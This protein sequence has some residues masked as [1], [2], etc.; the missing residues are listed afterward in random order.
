[1]IFYDDIIPYNEERRLSFDKKLENWAKNVEKNFEEKNSYTTKFNYNF[2]NVFGVI[3]VT[4]NY[5]SVTQK[6]KTSEGEK[7]Y[8]LKDISSITITSKN[9]KESLIE[10]N[11]QSRTE[12]LPVLLEPKKAEAILEIIKRNLNNASR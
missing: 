7:V 9:E 6:T 5:I 12:T 4:P 2:G 8:F 3:S 10:L 1:M 11:F